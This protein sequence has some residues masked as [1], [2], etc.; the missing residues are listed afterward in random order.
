L[1]HLVGKDPH[2]GH[3]QTPG[4]SQRLCRRQWNRATTP[5]ASAN[6]RFDDA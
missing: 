2:L 3:I 1:N 6:A 4:A 5:L